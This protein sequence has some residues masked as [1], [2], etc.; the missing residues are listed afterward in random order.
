ME[1][2]RPDAPAGEKSNQGP[3]PDDLVSPDDAERLTAIKHLPHRDLVAE[4]TAR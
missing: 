3:R 2:P 1:A 4:R